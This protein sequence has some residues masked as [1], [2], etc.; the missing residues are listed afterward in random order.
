[1]DFIKRSANESD[2]V[3]TASHLIYL[4]GP[5]IVDFIH[6]SAEKAQAFGAFE[7]LQGSGL[8][9]FVST[10]VLVDSSGVIATAS[11]SDRE[12]QQQRFNDSFSNLFKYYGL[13]RALGVVMRARKLN[14]FM[15]MPEEGE[16]YLSNFAVRED[17]QGRGVG[18]AFLDMLIDDARNEGYQI[19]SLDV[20]TRNPPAQKL[21]TSVGMALVET[22]Q[23]P[24]ALIANVNKMALALTNN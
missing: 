9:G 4:S 1:M 24:A 16:I 8:S 7:F 19:F 12:S 2:S 18:R 23:S 3:K 15:T 5:D 20:S 17:L 21:Y 13:F 10:I 22:K 11:L 14:G 6:G